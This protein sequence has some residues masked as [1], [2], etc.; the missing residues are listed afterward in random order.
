MQLLIVS[1]RSP[2][3]FV[4]AANQMHGPK[5]DRS[6]LNPTRQVDT[7]R[8]CQVDCRLAVCFRE[9]DARCAACS[10]SGCRVVLQMSQNLGQHARHDRTGQP[11]PPVDD[12]IQCGVRVGKHRPPPRLVNSGTNRPTSVQAEGRSVDSVPVNFANWPTKARQNFSGP[13]GDMPLAA[14]RLR[15]DSVAWGSS[16]ATGAEGPP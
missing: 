11:I 2:S 5:H 7:P 12:S 10:G 13:T 16:R 15:S 6:L 1:H 8:V 4:A 14:G 9:W 3:C